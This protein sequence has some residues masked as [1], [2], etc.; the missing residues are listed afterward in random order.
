V[1]RLAARH[2]KVAMSGDGGDESFAGYDRYVGQRLVDYYCLLPA[3]LRRKLMPRLIAATP[4]T[5]RY[6]SLAQRLSWLQSMSELRGGER[7]ARALGVLRFTPEER[8]ELF[9]PEAV[10]ALADPDTLGKVLRYFDA[11]NVETLTD[12]MLYTDLMIRVPDHNLVMGDRMSMACSLEVRSPFMDPRVVEFAASLPAE[13]KLRGR[14]LKYLLRRVAGRYLPADVVRRPKQ[15]FG[16]PVGQWMQRDLRRLVT[17]RLQR[18]RLVAAGVFRPEPLARLLEEHMAGRVDHSY[19]LWL[20][21]NL[22]IWYEIYIDGRS[23]AEV[24]AEVLAQSGAPESAPR[25]AG[26]PA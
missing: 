22:E 9:H 25:L 10:R 20:L 3:V 13:L 26:L 14:R 21:L 2:V 7:Y 6:K 5:F 23:V 8:A 15:G 1:S 12:R 16:F 17:E 4:E 24:Q 11:P 18:S 19:R